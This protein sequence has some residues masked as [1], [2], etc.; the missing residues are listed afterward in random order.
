MKLYNIILF[1]LLC[2]FLNLTNVFAATYYVKPA[3]EGGDDNA[4]G[5]SDKTAWATIN[6]VN[7]AVSKAGDDV[8]FKCDC[9][10]NAVY[11]KHI[12]GIILKIGLNQ[13]KQ[14]GLEG[15]PDEMFNVLKA[16]S[17]S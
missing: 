8:Y 12:V 14:I 5:L 11:C 6:K 1:I 16:F 9:Q 2:F 17:M 13:I 7:N 4:D 15:T 3:G 10:Q